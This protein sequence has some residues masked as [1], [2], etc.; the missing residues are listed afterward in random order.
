MSF[1]AETLAGAFAQKVKLELGKTN[2]L[3]LKKEAR[4]TQYPTSPNQWDSDEFGLN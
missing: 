4:P 1:R 3:S 2:P